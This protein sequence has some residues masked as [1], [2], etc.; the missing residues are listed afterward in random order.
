MASGCFWPGSS[1]LCVPSH[2]GALRRFDAIF[3]QLSPVGQTASIL[4]HGGMVHP[5]CSDKTNAMPFPPLYPKVSSIWKMEVQVRLVYVVLPDL[6]STQPK[7]SAASRSSCVSCPNGHSVSTS[8]WHQRGQDLA[9]C[10]DVAAVL[11]AGGGKR[12][13]QGMGVH[14]ANTGPGADSSGC[15]CGNS[16]APPAFRYCLRETGVRAGAAP[17]LAQQKDQIVRDRDLTSGTLCF[18]AF[19]QRF[20][21]SR[22]RS[23]CG[24]PCGG[25]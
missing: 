24:L 18:C 15:S 4:L 12:M 20:W 10:L 13:A 5:L 14:P 3:V 7:R 16:E 11:Q 22:R 23:K 2:R 19:E 8:R 6:F 9:Q 25:R 21:C 1:K 17:Q